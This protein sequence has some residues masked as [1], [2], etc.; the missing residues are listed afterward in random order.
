[1]TPDQTSL[2]ADSLVWQQS[3]WPQPFKEADAIGLLRNWAAQKHAPQL[4]LEARADVTGVEYLIGSQLRHAL[5]VR[6]S[7]EQLVGGSIVTNFD[8]TERNS[9]STARR[10]KLTTTVRAIEPVDSVAS[11]RSILSALTA[12]KKNERLV[13]QAIIGPRRQPSL[14]PAELTQDHQSVTSKLLHGILSNRQPDARQAVTR[15]L[16]QHGFEVVLRLG[17]H[18]ITA[19]RRRT[20][21]MG[22]VAAI[23]TVEAAGV[24]LRLVNEKAGRINAPRSS[25]SLFMPSQHLS[26]PEVSHLLAWPVSDHD[27]DVFPGQPPRH[28]KPVRPTAAAQSGE[29]T[30][31]IANAPGT[32]GTIGYNVVDATRHLWTMGPNGVGK[33]SLFLNLIVGDLEAGRPVVVIEPKDLVA[34]ILAR[35]P[36]YRKDDVV[37]L[38]PL[39]SAPI[40][41]NPLD[42]KHR[43]GRTP[44]VVADSLFS[45]FIAI[46]GDSLGHRSADILRN[47][48]EVLARR[49]DASLV[50]LPLLLTNP[51][52]RRSLT[53]QVIREDPYAAGPFWQWFDGLSPEA[54][55]SIVAPLSN[56]LRP[57]M[58]K[59][60]RSVLAQRNPKFNIRQVLNERKILLVP[61]QKGVIGPESAQLLSA[62][63]LYELWQAILERAGAPENSRT[64]VMVYVDEVQEFLKFSDDIAEALALSRSLRAAFHL[65]HQHEAQLPKQMLEAFKNNARSRV[66]FQLQAGDAKDVTAGQSVLAPEDFSSLPAFQVYASVIR[67]NSL[68]PWASGSTL[69]PPPKTSDPEEIRRHSRERYG[70][71]LDEIEAGFAEFLDSTSDTSTSARRKRR[72]S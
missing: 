13:I 28:P 12:V 72:Q 64:P 16:G 11:H 2:T 63:V 38:D 69:P 37:V 27:S 67:D 39:D 47:C 32:Q 50:M 4:V 22:L 59:Q 23:G 20:L 25:W 30:I 55:A 68:Q 46:Y 9:V 17:V 8:P 56:K 1:M 18:A 5:A 57:L 19:E 71:P 41:I 61:L 65:A 62:A 51:G 52:F 36:E 66:F 45:M 48:L 54:T 15:K 49:D 35:I 10:L 60:L 44:Q 26:V 70:Q 43:G 34:D 6:R 40:G 24:H 42:G 58:T 33:S 53:Q 29:R 31:A 14:P 21:L 3:H 7:I